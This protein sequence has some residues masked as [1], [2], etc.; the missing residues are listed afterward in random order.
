MARTNGYRFNIDQAVTF[1]LNG[2]DYTG[3]VSG[4]EEWIVGRRYEI[5]SPSGQ[6]IYREI[7]ERRMMGVGDLREFRKGR[8]N[9]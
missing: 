7:A 2:R 6:R 3:T 8:R 4:R 1:E 9:G 5:R